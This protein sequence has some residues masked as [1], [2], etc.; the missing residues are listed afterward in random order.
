MKAVS[1]ALAVLVLGACTAVPDAVSERPSLPSCAPDEEIFFPPGQGP[2]PGDDAEAALRAIDCLTSAWESGQEAELE[3]TLMGTEGQEYR[4][5]IQVLGVSSV[6]YF[7]ESDGG[8]EFYAGCS[9]ISFPEPGIPEPIK[10]E[11]TTLP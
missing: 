2:G 8:W 1:M 5:I 9:N 10:C 4:A 3:F 7:R 6:D 11:S